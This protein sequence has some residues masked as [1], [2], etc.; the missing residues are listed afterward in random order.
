MTCHGGCEAKIWYL[1]SI[2]GKKRKGQK[3]KEKKWQCN[4]GRVEGRNE[5]KGKEINGKK[6][7]DKKGKERKETKRKGRE[8]HRR[9]GRSEIETH[10]SYWKCKLSLNN[11]FLTSLILSYLILSYF[12]LPS[13][14]YLTGSTGTL[15]NALQAYQIA[16]DL[17]ETENQGFVLNII[18]NF[19]GLISKKY[20]NKC[21]CIALHCIIPLSQLLFFF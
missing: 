12:V 2:K 1:M 20:D 9:H 6:E 21:Y 13:D 3:G 4:D 10:N 11:L 18:S 8:V 17:Q 14:I 16:F 5:K 15:E 7:E 19:P